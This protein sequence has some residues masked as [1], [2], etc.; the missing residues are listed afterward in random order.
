M[1]T[2]SIVRGMPY[3][4]MHYHMKAGTSGDPFSQFVPTVTAEIELLSPPIV[5][6]SEQMFCYNGPN[7][8]LAETKLVEKSVLLSFRQSDFSWLVF[9]SHPVYV[10]CFESVGSIPFLLQVVGLADGQSF[11]AQNHVFTSRVAL[12]NNCTRGTNPSYCFQ[13]TPTDRKDFSALLHKHAHIYPGAHSK[14][15]YTFFSDEILGG[16]PRAYLQF[17]W[18]PRD[19]RSGQKLEAKE[20]ESQLL[21]YSLPHHRDR[22]LS[23]VQSPN[24]FIFDDALHCTP[25]LNGRACIV[26]GSNWVMEEDLDGEPSFYAPRRPDNRDLVVLAQAISHDIHFELPS[27]FKKGA[28]DTYFS[29]KML[30]KLARIIMITKELI[31]ICSP[32]ANEDIPTQCH[33]IEL[34]SEKIVNDAIGRLK[35]NTE[36]WINGNAVTPF[37][38]DNKW[39]GIVSCGC[40]FNGAEQTCYNEFPVCPSF[41]DHGLD[42]GH[43]V[44][45]DHHFHQGYHIYAAAAASYLDPDWG[46]KNFERVLIMIR[47]IA[48]Y[49]IANN[50]L[51]IYE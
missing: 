27:Y 30:A 42:F 36:I 49:V 3:G 17:D 1:M 41:D 34:P 18:D 4:T 2:S 15:D 12:M 46:K 35:R 22:I 40:H 14:I 5:D 19:Y 16:G 38:Y 24:R 9:Y 47:D 37:V 10:K 39:G 25:S 48:K 31:D 44:Y 26:E 23:A 11:D 21:M 29:G 13:A 50:T 43:G 45:N 33:E 6:S 28:G 8:T 20:D 51:P 7:N 32:Y